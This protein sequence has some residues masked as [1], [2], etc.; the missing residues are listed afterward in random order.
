[1]SESLKQAQVAFT[2]KLASMTHPDAFQLVRDCQGTPVSSVGPNT[3]LL[4]VGM[5][6]WPLVPN[7]GI[8]RKLQRADKV[9]VRVEGMPEGKYNIVDVKD[10]KLVPVEAA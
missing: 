1:M 5:L 6:G 10:V 7:G 9:Y 3:S 4:V 8:S 2:G